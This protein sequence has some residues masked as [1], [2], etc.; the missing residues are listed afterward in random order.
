LITEEQ[1]KIGPDGHPL[2]REPSAGEIVRF[3]ISSLSRDLLTCDV[4]EFFFFHFTIVRDTVV[5]TGDSKS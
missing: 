1:S 3:L 5:V 2:C 4:Q